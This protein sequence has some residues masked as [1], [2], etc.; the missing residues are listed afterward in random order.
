MI[1]KE[2]SIVS[3]REVSAA[4]GITIGG[5]YHYFPNKEELYNEITERYYIDYYKFNM[6]E[7]PQIKGNAKEKIHEAMVEILKQKETGIKI[8]SMMMK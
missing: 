6:D 5:I 2:K 7:L 4:T 1:E 8:E 3:I